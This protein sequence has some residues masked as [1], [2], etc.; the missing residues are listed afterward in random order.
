MAGVYGSFLSFFPELRQRVS[1]Y[2]MDASSSR[3]WQNRVHVLDV[4]C[5]IQSSEGQNIKSVLGD[6]AQ[7][8]TSADVLWIDTSQI[9]ESVDMNG[10]FFQ[11]PNS[12]DWGRVVKSVSFRL[13]G[14]FVEYLFVRVAVNNGGVN[15]GVGINT[16]SF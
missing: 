4:S 7:I 1:F 14:S 11:I 3:G 9:P 2:S 10:L 5:I 16:G 6:G 15:K 13:E 12:P 8:K